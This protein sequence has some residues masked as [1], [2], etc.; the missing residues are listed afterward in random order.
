MKRTD[1]G[2]EDMHLTCAES[3]QNIDNGVSLEG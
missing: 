3:K 2:S 1:I